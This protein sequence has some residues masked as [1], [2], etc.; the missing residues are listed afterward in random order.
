MKAQIIFKKEVLFLIRVFRKQTLQINTLVEISKL[1]F[2][3]ID[4][5]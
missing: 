1:G 4:Y 3:N 5:D 2:Q